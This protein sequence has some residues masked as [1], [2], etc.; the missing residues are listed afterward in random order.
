ALQEGWFQDQVAACVERKRRDAAHRK[1]PVTGVSEF[2]YLDEETAEVNLVTIPEP[3]RPD[4]SR[5]LAGLENPSYA[6]VAAALDDGAT[7][8][9]ISEVLLASREST[10]RPLTEFRPSAVYEALRDRSDRYLERNGRRPAL[11]GAFIGSLADFSAR[12]MF[13]RNL[14]AAGGVT[15]TDG[16]SDAGDAEIV[17]AF[18]ASGCREAV[19]CSGDDIYAGRAVGLATALKASG[20][21]RVWLAGRPGAAEADYTAAGIDGCIFA[22]SDAE[23]FLGGIYDRLEGGQA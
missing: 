23:S 7:V 3:E 9:Q 14:A 2:P 18:Q 20:A 15:I 19:L 4:D 12:A 1:L 6:T 13:A 17:A 5:V 22:G 11:F 16:P 8:Q 10:A 21:A